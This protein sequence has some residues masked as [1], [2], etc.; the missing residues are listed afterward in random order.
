MNLIHKINEQ[1]SKLNKD[2]FT[3]FKQPCDFLEVCIY[4]NIYNGNYIVREFHG[5]FS[6]DFYQIPRMHFILE[7]GAMN[8]M[9]REI[10]LLAL[11]IEDH[12]GERVPYFVHRQEIEDESCAFEPGYHIHFF[13]EADDFS[14][15]RISSF[16]TH[17]FYAL[18]QLGYK[19][20]IYYTV[21]EEEYT[22]MTLVT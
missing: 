6:P 9:D 10:I 16:V 15:E 7:L 11:Q 19:P 22:I 14:N 20:P 3:Y 4:N 18:F 13:P 21:N 5:N 17:L 12:L 2:F 1:G 8:R